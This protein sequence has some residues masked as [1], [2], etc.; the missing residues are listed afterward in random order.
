MPSKNNGVVVLETKNVL[1]FC[2]DYYIVSQITLLDDWQGVLV[3]CELGTAFGWILDI[4]TR[5]CR[6]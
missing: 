1:Q 3:L 2:T 4:Y 5:I 6:I